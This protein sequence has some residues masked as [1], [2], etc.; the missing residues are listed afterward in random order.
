MANITD[1]AP[2]KRTTVATADGRGA[3]TIADPGPATALSPEPDTLASKASL[4]SAPNPPG[5]IQ[6]LTMLQVKALMTQIAFSSSNGM[7]SAVDPYN[8]VGKYLFN[9]EFLVNSGYVKSDYYERFGQ[10][11]SSGTVQITGAWTGKN[12]ISSLGEFLIAED[13]QESLMY[14][15][16]AENYTGLL[17]NG[18]IKTTDGPSVVMGMLFVAH[19]IGTKNAKIWR[20]TAAGTTEDNTPVGVFYSQGRY[21]GEVLSVPT[22]VK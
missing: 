14:Q 4:V 6:I 16:L 19:K 9:T 18:G 1:T 21:A 12:S 17:R 15:F 3:A 2:V 22:G 11:G 5:G 10:T 8:N 7:Y 20:E 13:T